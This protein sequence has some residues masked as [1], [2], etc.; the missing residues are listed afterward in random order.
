VEAQCDCGAWCDKE[1]KGIRFHGLLRKTLRLI[2]IVGLTAS[3]A[4]SICMPGTK[5]SEVQ[6]AIYIEFYIVTGIK[7]RTDPKEFF[8]FYMRCKQIVSFCLQL[9]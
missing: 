1:I 2:S 3:S 7:F 5:F 6:A 4:T 8:S 9:Q